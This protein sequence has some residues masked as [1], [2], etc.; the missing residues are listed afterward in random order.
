MLIAGN[1]YLLTLNYSFVHL[2]DTRLNAQ[3]LHT[4]LIVYCPIFSKFFQYFFSFNCF[5][6]MLQIFSRQL[7]FT[8]TNAF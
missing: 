3:H 6:A 2:K 4:D 5:F 1:H 8:N 7:T